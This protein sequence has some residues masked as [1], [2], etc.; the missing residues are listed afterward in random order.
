MESHLVKL[1]FTEI[2]HEFL[3]ALRLDS[4][5]YVGVSPL[6]QQQL[7]RNPHASIVVDI[8][9]EASGV[10]EEELLEQIWIFSLRNRI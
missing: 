6:L 2:N 4:H 7:P 8:L 3:V 9:F 5:R 10:V 1:L